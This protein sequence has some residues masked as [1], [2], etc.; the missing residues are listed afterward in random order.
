M[1]KRI[2]ATL[3]MA[4]VMSSAMAQH[5][6][7]DWG[8]D[9]R[10]E[11]YE[12]PISA[13]PRIG[14]HKLGSQTSA[15]L[16]AKGIQRV[17]VVLVAFADRPF[18][19]ADSTNAGANAYYQKFCNGTLDG[20]LYR[21]HGS[22]GSIRDYFVQQSD[23]V[24][25]PEFTVIGPVTLDNGFA[26]Y[27][28]NSGSTKDKNFSTFRN[29]SIKKAMEIYTQWNDFDNDGNGTIDMVFFIFAGLGE[30]NSSDANCIWP[31]E[32]TAATTINGTVFST[33][34]CTCEKRP[35]TYTTDAQG[36]RIVETTRNDG[37]GVFIH[38]LSHALGLPDFYDTKNVA[39]GMDVWSVMDYGVYGVDGG[40]TP[41]NYT[42]YE[43]DFMGWRPLRELSEP[44]IL[45]LS[46][47]AAGGY[48]YK[49]Q[50]DAN[51]NEYYIIEN[52]QPQG[53]DTRICAA[54]R[55]GLQVTHVDYA[56]SRWSGNSVN[57]DPTHQ[58]M[59]IIA[60]NNLYKGTNS[61][62]SSAEWTTTL[63]GNLF[64]GNTYNYALTDE[65]T[66]AAEVFTGSLMHKPIR[67]ITENADGTI[68]LCYRTNGILDAPQASDPE[69]LTSTGFDAVWQ[70]VSNATRY[71]C[72]LSVG[73]EV[74]ASDTLSECI[75]HYVGYGGQ[76]ELKY[77]IQAL[78]DSPE[79]YLPSP[80]SDFVSFSTLT[81]LI[82][83]RW[84]ADQ[85]VSV[86]TTGGVRVANVRSSQLSRLA[87]RRGVYVL[88]FD[89]GTSWKTLLR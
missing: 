7:Q 47:F 15:P 5:E 13:Q 81:D 8:P 41:G 21:G 22:Y 60:A 28:A 2:F 53:W 16:R 6:P 62:T 85:Q 1:K 33:S 18:T 52:R 23:S 57:T 87:L 63:A 12:E 9:Q 72:E 79:D 32:S 34:G 66:P 74:M 55:H 4:M 73:D 68:T 39:F 42:A 48:G 75:S 25:F 64:P 84:A 86:F 45:T 10:P 17:P 61:A 44:C 88:R 82:R 70:P 36:N 24:F 77:R 38:E 76:T 54:T 67:N 89:D 19:T 46:C 69:N 50:N 27:G 78:A 83:D 80:W 26:Y 49:I 71:V 43:R 65:S 30:N 14:L 51:A 29:E 59:T 31:K 3:F 37:V 40:F 58:R 56:S 20:N 35:A 11:H